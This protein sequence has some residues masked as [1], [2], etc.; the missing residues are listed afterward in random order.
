VDAIDTFVRDLR[1]APAEPAV[2][3]GSRETRLDAARRL[4]VLRRQHQA[5]IGRTHQQLRDTARTSVASGAARVVLVHRNG[6]FLDTVATAL[7]G[8]GLVVVARL[9]NGADAIGL[10]LCEQPDIVL[11]EDGL[12]MVPGEDVLRQLRRWCPGARLVAQC[13]HRSRIQPL[14]DAGAEA[15][16]SR[17]T[18]PT[19]V[20]A[21]MFELWACE[22][23][24][25]TGAGPTTS[26]AL[27]SRLDL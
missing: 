20:G 19:D 4:D 26:A 17:L 23:P 10:S 14:L 13:A 21:A 12:L 5:V 16:Y 22:R 7:R 3:G 1:A 2:P 15:V 9:D 11:V 6:W 27:T 8:R 24:S 18:P 25:G